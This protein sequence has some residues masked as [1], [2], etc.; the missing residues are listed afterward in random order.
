[1]FVSPSTPPRLKAPRRLCITVAAACALLG[2]FSSTAL[3]SEGSGKCE[4]QA[5]SQPFAVLGDFNY[6]TLAPGSQFNSPEEGWQLSGG[7]QI[8]QASRPEGTEGGVLEL[9]YGA[10]AVSPPMCVTLLYPTARMYVRRLQG[11]G[12]VKVSVSYANLKKPRGVA[13]V[14]SSHGHWA[15]SE[16]FEVRPQLGG[17]SEESREVRFILSGRGEETV[18]D[19]YGIYVDPRMI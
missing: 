10:E 17:E 6:Y 12:D 19:V 2:I 5:F 1:M 18:S 8:V 13:S 11:S 14:H 16:P 15:L 4:G 3:A 7:A 9:P